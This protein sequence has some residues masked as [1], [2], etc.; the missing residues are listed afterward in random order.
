MHMCVLI[1]WGFNG[2]LRYYISEYHIFDQS[3]TFTDVN[4]TGHAKHS[5]ELSK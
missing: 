1:F 5:S 2:V 3:N 4:V